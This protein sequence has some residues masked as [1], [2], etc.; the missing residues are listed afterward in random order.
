MPSHYERTAMSPSKNLA[1]TPEVYQYLLDHNPPL[2][3][4]QRRLVERARDLGG[5]SRLR[6]AP[7][8]DRCSP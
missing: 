8:R 1:I 3:E 4:P 6:V 7:S 5:V 2:D